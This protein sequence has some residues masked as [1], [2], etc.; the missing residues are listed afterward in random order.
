MNLKKN[1][2]V[3]ALT[4]ALAAPALAQTNVE[5]FNFTN[6]LAVPDASLSGLADA[7][8]VAVLQP[9]WDI[10]D[11]NVSLHLSGG[12]NGDLYA[13]LT[14]NSGFSVLLNR[15]GRTGGNPF[16]YADAGFNVTFDD[17]AAT[18]VHLYG[19]NGG[20]Q[21]T[22]DFQP[23]ARNIHPL[24][25][26]DTT[27]RSAFLN[28]FNFDTGDGMWTLFVADL[29]SGSQSVLETWSLQIT[30]TMIP[31]PGA[32]A[33]GVLGAGVFLY[34]MRRRGSRGMAMQRIDSRR[35]AGFQGRL[36]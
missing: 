20:L 16:G 33:L 36:D 2:A 29:S 26:L 8:L 22:G 9:T 11:V 13:F 7:R 1:L 35:R 18:D 24:T 17:D 21:L 4:M 15:S 27:G 31:E 23:D 34:A 19:G 30:T 6:G 3:I 28:S 25:V 5:T 14:H 32:W 12:F 10:V